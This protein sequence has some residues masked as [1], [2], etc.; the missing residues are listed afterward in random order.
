MYVKELKNGMLLRP[1]SGWEWNVHKLHETGGEGGTELSDQG[2]LSHCSVRYRY[3]KVGQ[4]NNE[5]GMYLGTRKLE[6]TYYGLFTHHLVL[7]N[8]T[9]A[10]LDGYSFADIEKV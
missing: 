1:K 9:V 7:V 5:L 2:V 6:Q 8:G 10:A 4:V 3:H